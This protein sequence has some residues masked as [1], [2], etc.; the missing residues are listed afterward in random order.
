MVPSEPRYKSV[1]DLAPDLSSVKIRAATCGKLGPGARL[2]L[3]LRPN[4]LLKPR[5]QF[6]K[7]FFAAESRSARDQGDLAFFFRPG[8]NL[9][10]R[11]RLQRIWRRSK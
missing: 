9:F 8:D 10:E 7:T 1:E 3:C 6:G 4:R 2:T 11:L 5:F